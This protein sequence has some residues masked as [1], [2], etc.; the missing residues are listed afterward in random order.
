MDVEKELKEIRRLKK[1]SLQKGEFA[2][3]KSKLDPYRV[4]IFELSK[5]GAS[6]SEIKSYILT[7]LKNDDKEKGFKLH[8]TTIQKYIRRFTHG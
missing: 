2:R 6:L 1:I 8:R 4:Q 5:A 3:R 7:N